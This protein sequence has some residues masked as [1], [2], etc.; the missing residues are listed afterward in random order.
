MFAEPHDSG[1]EVECAIAIGLTA[2]LAGRAT[3]QITINSDPLSAQ[4]ALLDQRVCRS[5]P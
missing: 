1:G 2:L 5:T 4:V 3:D